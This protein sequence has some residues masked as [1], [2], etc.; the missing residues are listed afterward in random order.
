MWDIVWFS[1]QGHRSVSVSRHLLLQA[2]QCP[3]SVRKWFSRDHCCRGRSKPGCRVAT[4]QSGNRVLTSLSNSG[5]CWTVFAR[6][7]DTAVPAEGNGDLQTLICVLVARTRQCPTLS[8]PVPWQ[9]WMA[10]CLSYTLWMK[11]LFRGWP[12]MVHDTHTRRRSLVQSRQYDVQLQVTA[13]W[14]WFDWT[15][16]SLLV[17]GLV[18]VKP[19]H[20]RPPVLSGGVTFHWLSV[21]LQ[22]CDTVSRVMW[23]VKSYRKWSMMINQTILIPCIWQVHSMVLLSCQHTLYLCTHC[24]TCAPWH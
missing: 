3:C 8:N 21:V 20:N 7:R 2:P 6:N 10:A 16:A 22:C 12:V 5:L 11:M 9:N 19:A 13:Y 1:P 14:R 18:S 17:N 24:M 23:P 4:P 15:M